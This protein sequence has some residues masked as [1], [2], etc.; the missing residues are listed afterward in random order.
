MV[1]VLRRWRSHV[2]RFLGGSIDVERSRSSRGNGGVLRGSKEG[3][4]KKEERD[5]YSFGTRGG[6]RE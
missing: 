2:I 6:R 3:K 5:I 4:G 1:S